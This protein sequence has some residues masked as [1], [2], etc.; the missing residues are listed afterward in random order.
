MRPPGDGST[1]D[2]VLAQASAGL[3]GDDVADLARLE[4]R[5]TELC[6]IMA[7][8][9]PTL[10]PY[11]VK[12]TRWLLGRMQQAIDA[13]NG[14]TT[15]F[16]A[17]VRQRGRALTRR[18]GGKRHP[19]SAGEQ[20]NDGPVSAVPRYRPGKAFVDGLT[21]ALPDAFAGVDP[22]ERYG[23]G[24]EY[25]QSWNKPDYDGWLGTIAL[26]DAVAWLWEHAVAC[27]ARA[28]TSS[29]RPGGEKHLAALFDYIEVVIAE[30]GDYR[31]IH[32]IDSELFDT[33]PWIEAV[34]EH[35]GP[36]T[37]A[38]LREAQEIRAQYGHT[39]VGRWRAPARSDGRG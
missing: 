27:D 37:V 3:R 29:V 38:R 9:G 13:A 21:S 7:V 18:N 11:E 4:Q 20:A 23:Y 6:R 36:L 28:E 1:M 39:N 15:G 34:S 16:G 12:T 19:L 24:L 26:S 25:P 2:Y 10:N 31:G 30:A 5:T 22:K 35:L 14:V 32:W 33:V 8:S 17:R